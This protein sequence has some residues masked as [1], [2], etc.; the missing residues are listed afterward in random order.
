MPGTQ[1]HHFIDKGNIT[2][3]DGDLPC[4]HLS[5]GILPLYNTTFP[6]KPMHNLAEFYIIYKFSVS[7]TSFL[8]VFFLL[9]YIQGSKNLKLIKISLG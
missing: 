8:T 9:C 7:L 3:R 6:D 2:Q 1:Y 5:G 4:F